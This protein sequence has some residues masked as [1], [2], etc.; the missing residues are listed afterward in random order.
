[1]ILEIAERILESLKNYKPLNDYVTSRGGEFRFGALKEERN[2]L[3][4]LP[5]VY[6]TPADS[7]SMYRH[8]MGGSITNAK[9]RQVITYNFD[10]RCV[11]APQITPEDAERESIIMVEH[12]EDAIRANARLS[13][14]D[15]EN[16]LVHYIEIDKISRYMPAI[17]ETTQSMTLLLDVTTVKV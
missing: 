11:T 15:G 6:V 13:D 12:M 4:V 8:S 5:L 2:T 9:P 16:P 14:E 17:G 3:N 1:M 7:L 10:A